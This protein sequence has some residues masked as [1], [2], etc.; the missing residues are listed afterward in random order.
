MKSPNAL[1]QSEQECRRLATSHYENFLVASVLLPKRLRQPFYNVYAF[2]RTADDLADE[3]PSPDVATQQ[4]ADFQGQL[5]ETF[6][7]NPP[8]NLFV[9]LGHTIDEFS[10]PKQPFDDLLDA[11]RQDQSKTRYASRAELLNYCERSA[12]PVGRIVLRLADSFDER[13]A[14]LSD[15][16]CTGL[17][18]ANFWQDVARD[19]AIG[20]IYLPKDRMAAFQVDEMMLATTPTPKAVRELVKSECEFVLKLFDNGLELAHHVP[21]WFA[22][23]VRLFAHGGIETLKAIEKIDYNILE[24][25]PKVSRWTQTKLVGRAVFGRLQ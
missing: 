20:R 14:T 23:N 11:F 24:T 2:C 25:R 9:A 7:G 4:L 5:D 21:K 19:L 3:S 15:K 13:N 10:L 6:A 16:I 1:Q 18:L 8:Q 12:N 17:Q 22:S